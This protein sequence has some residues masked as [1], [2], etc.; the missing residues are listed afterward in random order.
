MQHDFSALTDQE[1]QDAARKMKSGEITSAVL[2]GFMIGIIIFSAATNSIGFLTL[3]PLYLA[4]RV[5]HNP[6]N[7]QRNAALKRELAERQLARR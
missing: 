7:N 4:F 1:M 2:I 6:E 3:I 5:F